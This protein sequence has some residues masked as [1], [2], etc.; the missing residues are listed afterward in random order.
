[1]AFFLFLFLISQ[2][3]SCLQVLN[4]ILVVDDWLFGESK[5]AKEKPSKVGCGVCVKERSG[6][7]V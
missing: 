6:V 3:S 5:M 4:S 1:M 7:C 2:R